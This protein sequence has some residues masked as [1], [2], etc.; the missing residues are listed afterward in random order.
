VITKILK[1]KLNRVLR[2]LPHLL[3]KAS[4]ILIAVSGG[5]DSLCLAQL[6]IFAQAK[7]D[8]KLAIAHCD[9]KWRHDSTDNALHVQ[10]IAQ[11]WGLP[12]YLRTAE[13]DLKS[14]ASARDWRYKML[15]EMALEADCEFVV[16]GHTE[17]DRAETLLYNLVRGSGADG[18]QSLGW[19][20]DLS[21]G[22]QLVRP[23]LGISRD[24][25]GEFCQELYLPVWL[26][27]TNQVL[28]YK[29]NRIREELIPY[30]RQHFN[31]AVQKALAQTAELLSA[32]VDYLETQSKK[33]WKKQEPR[34]NRVQL[35][36]A[37]IAIQRRAIHQFLSYYLPRTPDFNHVQRF[38]HLLGAANRSQSSPFA[39]GWIAKVDHPFIYL[40]QEPNPSPLRK[41]T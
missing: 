11:D 14:E 32:D 8:W 12:F 34:I 38:M 41:Y 4:N 7:W 1:T 24:E 29:R 23:L 19:Q 13:I 22:I 5:Q 30:L 10:K 37:D 18:L 27:S 31:P 25:T 2:P 3:P 39:E 6:L 21:S 28:D 40:Q 17:S 35:Q 36:N 15:L 16:T 33:L 20:R 26:D 9:H